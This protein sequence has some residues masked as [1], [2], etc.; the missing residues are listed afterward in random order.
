VLFPLL[1]LAALASCSQRQN[2]QIPNHLLGVW[3]TDA[4]AYTDRSLKLTKE[5]LTF[6]TGSF[7][8]D[9]YG[10]LDVESI[11][12][13]GGGISYT[14]HYLA[15]EDFTDRLRFTY[16]A[17]PVPTIRFAHRNELWTVSDP[18]SWN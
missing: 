10:V 12:A 18:R 11:N 1:L 3:R 14:I 5:T 4:P 15:S 7:G 6:E 16:R 17:G 8:P 9:I 13:G 2:R